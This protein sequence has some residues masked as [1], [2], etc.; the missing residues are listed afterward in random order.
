MMFVCL[1]P[2]TLLDLETQSRLWTVRVFDRFIAGRLAF[3]PD[4]SQLATGGS[5]AIVGVWDAK[6]LVCTHTISRNTKF[7]RSVSFSHDSKL[8]ASSAEEGG[9]DIALAENG[10]LVGKVDLIRPKGGGA[11]EIAFHPK[12]HLLACAKCGTYAQGGSPVTL[13]KLSIVPA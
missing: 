9:I 4:G 11:D 8:L 13:A 1:A 2:V 3:S 12:S 5:D 7:T 6:H 10:E